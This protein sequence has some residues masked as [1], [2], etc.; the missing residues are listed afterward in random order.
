MRKLVA[1]M[2]F[3][4]FGIGVVSAA[5]LKV[6]ILLTFSAMIDAPSVK[7]AFSDENLYCGKGNVGHFGDKDGP[8]DL[9]RTCYYTGLDATP[10]PGKQIKVNAKADLSSLL[11]NVRC[12]ETLLLP[13][14]AS[15]VVEEFPK[16]GCDDQHYITV[17]T[18][19]PDSKLPRE[20]SRISPAWAGVANLPG[21]PDYAQPSDGPA[22]Y[23]TTIVTTNVGGVTFGDHYRF[24]GIEWIPNAD[25]KIARILSTSGA[26]HI[27]FDRNWIHGLDGKELQTGVRITDGT[28]YIAVIH[29]YI[30]SVQCMAKV[31]A[32]TDAAGVG[33]GNGDHPVNTIK[34]VDNFVESSGENVFFGGAAATIR[35]EDVEVRRNHLFKPLFWNPNSPEHK[36][37]TPI[38][39]N[40]FE[41][42][43][44]N[45]LLFEAN[46]LENSW[47]GFSQSGAA[48]LL[49]PRNSYR[50]FNRV[51]C[52]NCAVTNVTIRYVWVRRANQLLF[53][54]NPLD[55][56]EPAPA[57]N[58]S[59]H[60]IVAEG[61]SYP[62]CGKGCGSALN[63]IGS[64]HGDVSAETLLHDVSVDHVTFVGMKQPRAL[65]AL[66]GPPSNGKDSPQISNISWTNT[67]ADVGTYGAWPKGGGPE[68]NCASIRR[69]SPKMRLEA[70]W[71]SGVFKG[72]LLAGAAHARGLNGEWP[73]G[74][75]HVDDLDAVGFVNLNGGLDGDYHL[76]AASKF[77]GKATDGKNPGADIDAVLHAINGVR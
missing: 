17:R 39:K 74:N 51:Y 68:N 34:I 66:G 65:F 36:D 14:G 43:S 26:D 42:K 15:F 73:D 23:M 37:P 54:G 25:K 46:Y 45:R 50:R 38:V 52:P 76:A 53:I 32:C 71:K 24:I 7:Q 77:Q 55:V 40:L 18:D 6:G 64:A 33:G 8:A 13:A 20:G 16:K 28:S 22:K 69:G 21:R 58:Y 5:A 61:L 48:I 75:H 30:N 10:S 60:D 1:A 19:T 9:P 59:I 35:A 67:I 12:G 3:C 72:N 27:I 2:F 57:H 11:Q 31:G 4:L 44:A 47:P 56:D 70:C 63:L 49:T 29:S 41:L 62:E